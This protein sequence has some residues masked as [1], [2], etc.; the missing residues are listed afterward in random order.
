MVTAQGEN[1]AQPVNGPNTL[2]LKH[3]YF[4]VTQL[5]PGGLRVSHPPPQAPAND[6]HPGIRASVDG[7]K[8]AVLHKDQNMFHLKQRDAH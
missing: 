2:L 3:F 8:A 7:G 5:L 4:H 1:G 6:Q